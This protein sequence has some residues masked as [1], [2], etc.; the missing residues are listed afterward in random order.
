MLVKDMEQALEEMGHTKEAIQD[1]R[2]LLRMHSLGSSD[3]SEM[4]KID[5]EIE[6]AI[7]Q[8]TP[9]GRALLD[10]AYL[11]EAAYRAWQSGAKDRN[12]KERKK[13]ERDYNEGFLGYY[14]KQDGMPFDDWI[15]KDYPHLNE[16]HPTADVYRGGE[17]RSGVS[18]WTQNG[19]GASVGNGI[20]IKPEHAM[21]IDDAL[22][23]GAI[24]LGG[25]SRMMGSS[26]EAEVTMYFPPA[27][28]IADL[29]IRPIKQYRF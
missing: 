15:K 13:L 12:I 7:A 17:L 8:D 16:D 21:T 26:G 25:L 24:M 11:E 10:G 1:A 29:K 6:N 23:A 3:A 27:T 5:A 9:A 14:D 22:D 19:N 4:R 20:R 2:Q 18:S 28:P